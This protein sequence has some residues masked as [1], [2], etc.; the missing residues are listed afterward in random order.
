LL[1]FTEAGS[2]LTLD[3]TIVNLRIRSPAKQSEVEYL[4]DMLRKADPPIAVQVYDTR[5]DE[6]LSL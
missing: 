3:A 6:V 5:T 1:A 4:V 2:L